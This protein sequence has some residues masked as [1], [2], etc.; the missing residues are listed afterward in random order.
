MK[1]EAA[2][3]LQQEPPASATLREATAGISCSSANVSGTG[4]SVTPSQDVSSTSNQRREG[5]E[6]ACSPHQGVELGEWGQS[7]VEMWGGQSGSRGTSS[8]GGD[9]FNLAVL[10]HF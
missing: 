7:L 8:D 5:G 1:V 3:A 9:P 2:E 6:G 10:P 4:T